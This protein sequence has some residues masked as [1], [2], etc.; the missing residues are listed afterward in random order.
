MKNSVD[1]EK[2]HKIRGHILGNFLDLES[3]INI[4]IT[5]HYCSKSK[6]GSFFCHVLPEI[7]V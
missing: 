5:R 2:M 3:Q 4:I 1:I 7:P 6:A